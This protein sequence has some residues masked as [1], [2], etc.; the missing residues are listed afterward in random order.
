MRFASSVTRLLA[1]G[2]TAIVLSG[3]SDLFDPEVPTEGI[4]HGPSYAIGKRTADSKHSPETVG[5]YVCEYVLSFTVRG[6]K[7]DESYI[8]WAGGTLR[9]FED[10]S[11][12]QIGAKN[13]LVDELRNMWR[14][15]E[16]LWYSGTPGRVYTGTR[17]SSEDWVV[18]ADQM[19]F[20][21]EWTMV[22]HDP[23]TERTDS[24][25]WV[26]RCLEEAPK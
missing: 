5:P 23:I 24:A 10:G 4:I 8:T 9:V 19:P 25:K 22:F 15:Y 13:Y 18:G 6:G 20:R 17:V 16:G 1:I 14:N 12:R 21:A 2:T 11:D 3:C 7:K 26:S